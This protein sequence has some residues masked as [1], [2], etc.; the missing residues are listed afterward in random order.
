[1]IENLG[2]AT[3]D[4]NFDG[5]ITFDD[6]SVVDQAFFFQGARLAHADLT[7]VPEPRTCFMGA[8]GLAGVVWLARRRT[9]RT[10]NAA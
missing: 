5:D 7:A 6:Y 2:W 1:L 8:L 10:V 3:G 9:S 4:I